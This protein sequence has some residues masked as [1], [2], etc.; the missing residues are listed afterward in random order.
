MLSP[1][2][3]SSPEKDSII[4]KL[5]HSLEV[6]AWIY[7]CK[8]LQMQTD[9]LPIDTAKANGFWMVVRNKKSYLSKNQEGN[10]SCQDQPICDLIKQVNKESIG[11]LKESTQSEL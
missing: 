11:F 2:V 7:N 8:K 6:I 9:V 10:I 1:S 5:V 3:I 4:S